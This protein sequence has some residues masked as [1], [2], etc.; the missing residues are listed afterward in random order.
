MS[1]VWK[2]NVAC[3]GAVGDAHALLVGGDTSAAPYRGCGAGVPTP[4]EGRVEA[5]S[6]M[7][8]LNVIVRVYDQL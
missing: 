5:Q 1:V 2:D 6:R 4:L 7:A 3:L 8:L